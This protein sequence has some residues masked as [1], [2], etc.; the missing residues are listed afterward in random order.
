MKTLLALV[1]LGLISGCG[2]HSKDIPADANCDRGVNASPCTVE[3]AGHS[4][5]TTAFSY[6]SSDPKTKQTI[7]GSE[8]EMHTTYEFGKMSAQDSWRREIVVTRL[9]QTNA[10][11]QEGTIESNDGSQFTLKQTSS[12]C[13][14]EDV[15]SKT[16]PPMIKLYYRRDAATGLTIDF[17]P[18]PPKPHGILDR[19]FGAIADSISDGIRKSLTE[20]FSWGSARQLLEQGADKLSSGTP[21]N[22][23]GIPLGCF[24]S[25]GHGYTPSKHTPTW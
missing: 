9:G 24:S 11:F 4:T 13:D 10:M 17:Q 12:S 22:L 14:D 3:V 1:L 21:P 16:N 18:L 5:W 25:F 2:K 19:L 6:S 20:A 7:P 8:V 23:T 15:S